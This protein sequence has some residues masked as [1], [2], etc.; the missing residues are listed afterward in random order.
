MSHFFDRNGRFLVVS[1]AS[2]AAMRGIHVTVKRVGAWIDPH[3]LP[4]PV[5]FL[6]IHMRLILL[7]KVDAILSDQFFYLQ[8]IFTPRTGTRIFPNTYQYQVFVEVSKDLVRRK[9][10]EL[11]NENPREKTIALDL[12]RHVALHT[13]PT[14]AEKVRSY[15]EDA[16]WCEDR[17]AVMND[18]FCDYEENGAKAWRIA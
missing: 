13:I 5:E 16:I 7:R 11:L 2:G 1:A 8:L 4:W 9:R 17:P 10:S 3:D 18:R 14:N 12:A 15:D 6:K